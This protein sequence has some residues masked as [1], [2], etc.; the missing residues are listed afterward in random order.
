MRTSL[1]APAL[2][3]TSFFATAAVSAQEIAGVAPLTPASTTPMPVPDDLL[4]PHPGGLTADQVG[5]RAMETS[6]QARQALETMRAAEARVDAAWAAFL[7]R[8]SGTARF[9]RL[10]NFT[11]P[12]LVSGSGY[13][14]GTTVAPSYTQ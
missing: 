7:P 5:V 8:L 10:S 14:V 12:S 1:F 11:P 3:L 4:A 6:F 9:T 2:L 13:G